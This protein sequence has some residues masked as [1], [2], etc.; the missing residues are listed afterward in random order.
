MIFSIT[1]C[2]K[3][4]LSIKAQHKN[5]KMSPAEQIGSVNVQEGNEEDF[6]VCFAVELQNE[7][8]SLWI[9]R[10]SPF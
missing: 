8:G 3:S 2:E 5:S 6:E 4:V 10:L 1:Y 7:G 9:F